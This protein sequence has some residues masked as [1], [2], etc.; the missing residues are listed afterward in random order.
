MPEPDA[1]CGQWAGEQSE[2]ARALGANSA[3]TTSWILTLIISISLQVDSLASGE[4]SLVLVHSVEPITLSA[5]TT[6]LPPKCSVGCD[7]IEFNAKA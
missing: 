5:N 2:Q 3:E 7:M 1:A 6:L 4:S